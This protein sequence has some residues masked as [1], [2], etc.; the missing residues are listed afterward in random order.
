VSRVFELSEE[1]REFRDVVRRFVEAKS[2]ESAVREQMASERGFD[3]VVWTEMAKQLGLQGL[4]VPEAYGGQGFGP[5]ELAVVMEEMGRGLLCAPYFS[6][7][8]LAVNALLMADDEGAKT[9]LLPEIASCERLVT[10][11]WSESNG[12]WDASGIEATAREEGGAYRIDGAKH[13]VLDGH[14]ADVLLVAARTPAGVSLFRISSD[15]PGVSRE[16]VPTL[17]MT[18]KLA[19]V[20]LDGA[21]ADLLGVDG[22]GWE[23]LSKVRDR[24]AVALAAEQVGGAQRCLDM[25]VDYAKERFQFGR[26]IGSFQAIKHKCADMLLEVECARSAAYYASWRAAEGRDDLPATAALAKATCSDAFLHVA[27]EN[28]Q[29]HGGIGFTWE[30]PAHL[31]FRRA[32]SSDLLL[33]DSTEQR[34]RLARHIGV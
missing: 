9:A 30:H 34:E 29:I 22:A 16:L 21:P 18:R 3:P 25:A 31:Y 8:V 12:R 23:T 1:Q 2:G 17:D 26:P 15:A 5:V 14:V 32:K 6:S 33:G 13:Y 20:A 28:I 7:A 19:R 27:R 4:I 11:A 10:V 24:A